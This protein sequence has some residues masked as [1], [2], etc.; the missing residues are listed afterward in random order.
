M[1]E[2][3]QIVDR[4]D[5]FS[6]YVNGV[7]YDSKTNLEWFAGPGRKMSWPE[8]KEWAKGL[9]TD[10]GDWRLPTRNELESLFQ[11]GKGNR[12]MTRLL[13]T[14]SWWVWS[15]EHEDDVSSNLFDFSRGSK[16]WHSRAPRAYAVRARK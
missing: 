8:A 5:H 6:K 3:S 12:N 15:A 10:G 14:E 11:E 1:Q 9:E 4:D 7:V 16:D 2:K 13:E